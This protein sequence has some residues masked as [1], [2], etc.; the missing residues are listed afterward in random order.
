MTV[1]ALIS[2]MNGWLWG[3]EAFLD[4]LRQKK[5]KHYAERDPRRLLQIDGFPGCSDDIMA[6]DAEGDSVL[7]SRTVELMDSP[8]STRILID[9]ATD[10]RVAARLLRKAAEWLDREPDL[11]ARMSA[12]DYGLGVPIW[13]ANPDP[14][15]EA[16]S[17]H[18]WADCGNMGRMDEAAF[19][20]MLTELL[21][22]RMDIEA[23]RIEVVATQEREG[24]GFY[25]YVDGEPFTA[26]QDAI[27]DAIL[28]DA[29]TAE[30]AR[31]RATKGGV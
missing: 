13:S 11:L 16:S 30:R 6:P 28:A 19:S 4:R 22:R 29:W 24:M 31:Q 26:E 18:W 2:E 10:P 23:S 12:E 14:I 5:L 7:G 8:F 20:T 3:Q 17:G 27:V 15:E 1:E 9:P 25:C 21:A